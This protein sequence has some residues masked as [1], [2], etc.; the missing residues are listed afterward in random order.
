MKKSEW[1][2]RRLCIENRKRYERLDTKKALRIRKL[3]ENC[4]QSTVNMDVLSFGALVKK[5]ARQCAECGTHDAIPN[6]QLVE[7]YLN[8]LCDEFDQKR[9]EIKD[10]VRGLDKVSPQFP[11]L[12]SVIKRMEDYATDRVFDS[13]QNLLKFIP[14]QVGKQHGY[15]KGYDY[16]KRKDSN[17][18]IGVAC[19]EFL[20]TGQCSNR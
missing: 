10:E 18:L 15:H 5:M 20:N 6:H 12:D 1:T 13:D 9:T 4:K 16:D 11:T 19:T 8:G 3:L 14:K 2:T 17:Q 7:Y